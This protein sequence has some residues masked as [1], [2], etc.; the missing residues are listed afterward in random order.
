MPAG[1]NANGNLNLILFEL[2]G[3]TRDPDSGKETVFQVS[4]HPLVVAPNLIQYNHNSRTTVV[5]TIGGSQVSRAPRAFRQVRLAG[6]WGVQSVGI[7]P[8]VGTGEVRAQRFADEVVAMSDALEKGEVNAL[9]KQ[10]SGTP[11]LKLKLARYFAQP[12]D[13]MF[14]INFYDLWND[15]KFQAIVRNYV[16]TR[17]A[18]RGGATGNI[19]YSMAVEEAGPLV[20]GAPGTAL[21]NKLFAGLSVWGDINAA[22]ETYT[23][24]SLVNSAFA[25]NGIAAAQMLRTRDAVV[26]Q[27]EAVTGLLGGFS[28]STNDNLNQ[29]LANAA[30][31]DRTAQELITAAEAMRVPTTDAPKGGVAWSSPNPDLPDGT[32]E[33]VDA[34]LA[35]IARTNTSFQNEFLNA[36]DESDVLD[37][38]EDLSESARWQL[39]AGKLFGYS[40]AEYQRLLS[41]G[42][43]DTK[44]RI[45]GTVPHTVGDA[46][47]AETI[48]ELYGVDFDE[49]LAWNDF[50]PDEA[51]VA[52]RRIDVPV[53]TAT[54]S[55]KRFASL[56]VFGSQFGEDAWGV[57]LDLELRVDTDGGLLT[58]S[59][60]DALIQG[61]NWLI[62]EA[63]DEIIQFA[64]AIPERGRIPALKA[65]VE[66]L[67]LIDKRIEAI[68]DVDVTITPEGGVVIKSTTTAINGGIVEIGAIG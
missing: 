54:V 40:T 3:I 19:G 11:F 61:A 2:L 10:F 48:E 16:D 30:E 24:Q 4:V 8:Y 50:T 25:V 9:I 36:M 15:R 18:R 43:R 60:T 6:D 26:G 28:S 67:L 37:G 47:T 45:T 31:L 59:G 56:P 23:A 66:A 21:L 32:V 55:G 35:E 68:E 63:Q 49:V 42:G 34:N 1:Q 62:E 52:G 29:F 39:V 12:D 33:G 64:N 65:K 7:L 46:D 53:T 38:L 27:I 57:D 14:A 44:R 51:L 13:T 5:Q 20:V 58:V 17:T 22:L 41:S